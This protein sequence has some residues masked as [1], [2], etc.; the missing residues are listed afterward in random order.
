M[1]EKLYCNGGPTAIGVWADFCSSFML[2]CTAKLVIE[3]S[4]SQGPEMVCDV[5]GCTHVVAK[6]MHGLSK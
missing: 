3:D 2:N 1:I 5:N 4:K 6:Y